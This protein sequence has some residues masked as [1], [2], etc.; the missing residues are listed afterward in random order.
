M[1]TRQIHRNVRVNIRAFDDRH[2]RVDDPTDADT[3]GETQGKN[4]TKTQPL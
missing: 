3:Q 1:A 4:R 2:R